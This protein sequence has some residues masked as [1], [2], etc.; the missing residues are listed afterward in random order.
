MAVD[1][2]VKLGAPY[3]NVT[4]SATEVIRIRSAGGERDDSGENGS[5]VSTSI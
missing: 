1:L 4:V 3:F 5:Q 2:R